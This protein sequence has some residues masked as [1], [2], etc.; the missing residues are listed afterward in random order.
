M[1]KVNTL[2]KIILR[3][4]WCTEEYTLSN[5]ITIRD[6]KVIVTMLVNGSLKSRID[7]NMI[8]HPWNTDFQNQIMNVFIDRERPFCNVLY[9]GG[10]L[11]EAASDT[12]WSNTKEKTGKL[13]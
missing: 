11:I 13:V 9:K 5:S 6:E 12:S 10:Y 7:P 3:F 2:L 4:K 8:T 1:K